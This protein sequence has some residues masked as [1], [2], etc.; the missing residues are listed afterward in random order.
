MRASPGERRRHRAGPGERG[1][2]DVRGRGVRVPRGPVP[3]APA[4]R[5]HPRGPRAQPVRRRRRGDD[6]PRQPAAPRGDQHGPLRRLPRARRGLGGDGA[7]LRVPGPARPPGGGAPGPPA[8]A[9]RRR[10]AQ[11]TVP[12]AAVA[13]VATH[14][15]GVFYLGALA[16]IVADRPGLVSGLLQVGV[17]NLLWYAVPLAALASWTWRPETTRDSAARLTAWVQAHKKHLIVTVFV[18]VGVY[19]VVVG[20]VDLASG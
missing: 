10:L 13:G 9:L 11:P 1:P 6:R 4:A 18:L 16:A 7:V 5:L 8:G 20:V 17:Y 14:L 12:N 3:H 15:P 2:P 19:L